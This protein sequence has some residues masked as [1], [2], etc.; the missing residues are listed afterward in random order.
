MEV[1]IAVVNG[2]GRKKQVRQTLQEKLASSLADYKTLMGEKKF[3]S[4]IR[5]AARMLGEDILKALPKKAKKN[6]KEIS[7]KGS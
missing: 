1:A 4:R 2:K 5:K 6:K 3:E 7:E